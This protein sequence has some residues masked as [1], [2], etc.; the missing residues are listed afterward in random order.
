VLAQLCVR[1]ARKVLGSSPARGLPRGDGPSTAAPNAAREAGR[2]CVV[3]SRLIA[4]CKFAVILQ[5]V[6]HLA[7]FSR[8][9][10]PASGTSRVGRPKIGGRFACDFDFDPSN[11]QECEC[12]TSFSLRSSLSLL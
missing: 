11:N 1:L 4:L 5:N 9:V 7:A 3:H 12:V 8:R 10:E 2:Q 6:F